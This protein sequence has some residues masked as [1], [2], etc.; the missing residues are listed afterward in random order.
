MPLVLFGKGADLSVLGASQAAAAVRGAT[1]GP[2]SRL[3]SR[4]S[5]RS[6][7]PAGTRA[8]T[9]RSTA[10]S[11][12]WARRRPPSWAERELHCY[13]PARPVPRDPAPMAFSRAPAR[14]RDPG[15]P[16][17]EP[18]P[19]EA[20]LEEERV[21]QVDG[22][23]GAHVD[24]NA[25]T[26]SLP[27]QLRRSV[28]LG[29]MYEV[30]VDEPV[31]LPLGDLARWQELAGGE[32]AVD[33][34][35]QGILELLRQA[36]H[37]EVTAHTQAGH[38][39]GCFNSPHLMSGRN[40]SRITSYHTIPDSRMSKQNDSFR[41][42]L[43]YVKC[44]DGVCVCCKPRVT[45]RTSWTR[46]TPSWSMSSG[47]SGRRAASRERRTPAGGKSARLHFVRVPVPQYN[48]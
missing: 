34:L 7:A 20:A 8:G 22:V 6:S 35:V 18:C 31:L 27:T 48:I 40:A 16:L 12:A 9:P 33:P 47:R 1:C 24:E 19:A 44:C 10:P 28:Q 45:C 4:G 15:C 14:G 17:A 39:E 26:R 41:A 46:G 21:R 43:A 5:R 25:A 32:V 3:S 36:P 37:A 38:M 11:W 13:T 30:P 29:A 2:P 23:E 42:M